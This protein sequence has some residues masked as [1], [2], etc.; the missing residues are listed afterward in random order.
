LTSI[1]SVSSAAEG[2]SAI[3]DAVSSGDKLEIR[4]RGT[5]AAI[6][7]PARA[8]SVL[9]TSGIAGIVDYDPAELVLTLRPATPLA[10]V[11]ALLAQRGQMLAFEPLDLAPV[12]GTGT[13]ATIGGTVAAGLAGSRRLTR[14]GVRDH[15]LG[16]T[17]VSGRG[18]IFV[19]GGKVV[20]N[21][22]GYDLPKLLARSWGRLALMTEL[23]LKV[24]P[25]P[26]EQE[27]R[28]VRG[29]APNEAYAAMAR[30]L[31]SQAE[32]A[33]AAYVPGQDPG[34]SVTAFRFEGFAPSITARVPVLEAVLEGYKVEDLADG[35]SFW[36]ALRDVSALG[37]APQLWRITLPARE[38]P[39][40][41]ELL[42]AKRIPWLADWA[43]GLI[44]AGW[45]S[46]P[47]ILRDAVSALGGY[48]SLIRAD[49]ETRARVPAFHP[50]PPLLGGLEARVRRAFDPTGVFENGRFGDEP[51]AN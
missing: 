42:N 21:V 1:V 41:A 34:E 50:L 40:L 20:K 7:K 43:G 33:A 2:V 25:A 6:G 16:F 51:D 44:W 39:R 13:T 46:E 26:R 49:A 37:G 12:H 3:L 18:E 22:T 19:A 11:E 10:E 23:T 31:G 27:T 36:A 32:I 24:L 14:G 17:A 8:G 48:A 15:L 4:G 47:Q 29:L 9:D 30:A 35:L 28:V 45:E 38:M 5:K